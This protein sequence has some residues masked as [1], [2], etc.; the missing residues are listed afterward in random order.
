MDDETINSTDLG[1]V[2]RL[3]VIDSSGRAYVNWDVEGLKLQ[4]QDDGK[5]LKLLVQ[6]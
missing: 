3:E 1:K 5:T 6:G 4:L 2:T